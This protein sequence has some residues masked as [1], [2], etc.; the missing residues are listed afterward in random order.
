LL[1]GLL[2]RWWNEWVERESEQ[3]RKQVWYIIGYKMDW[4][5]GL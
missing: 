2:R 4:K 1:M 5:W 3:A